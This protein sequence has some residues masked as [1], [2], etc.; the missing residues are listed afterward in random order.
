MKCTCPIT[1]L[2]WNAEYLS[3]STGQAHPFF[4]LAQRKIPAIL[5]LW[6]AQKLS[7]PETHLL[8]TRL[9]LD[10]EHVIFSTPLAL[11]EITSQVENAQME[12]LAK[13]VYSGC[14][15]KAN[16]DL[17]AYVVSKHNQ[18]ISQI[19][20]VWESELDNYRISAMIARQQHEIKSMLTRVQ[21]AFTN[22]LAKSR[23]QIITTW[24]LKC[25]ELPQFK[26]THPISK[27]AC[28]CQE[29]WIELLHAAIDGSPMLSYP[30]KDIVEFKE[31]LEEALPLNYAQE[32]SLLEELRQAINRKQNYFGYSFT[33]TDDKSYAINSIKPA[34]SRENFS[35]TSDFLAAIKNLRSQ[36]GL[37]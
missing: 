12:R 16:I 17:P 11:T 3:A 30:E 13:L 15:Q 23:K 26:I 33:D 8:F 2:V 27:Q 10:T 19:T 21:R 25:C 32:F 1:G 7:V 14:F 34:L 4:S 9:L 20:A 24:M 29:Y 35:S 31:H 18:D 6:Q 37:V 5:S 22:P 36:K 28:T